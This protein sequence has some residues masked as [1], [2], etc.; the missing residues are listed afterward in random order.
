M[1]IKF[2]TEGGKNIGFGHINRCLSLAQAFQELSFK[3]E[4]NI[5]GDDS[6]KSLIID[7]KLSITDW[8]SNPEFLYNNISID[9]IIVID[10]YKAPELLLTNIA[11]T[12]K[13]LIFFDDFNRVS[14]PTGF[15]VNGALNAEDLFKKRNE[16]SKYLLGPQF[17]T[18]RKEFWNVVPS[19]KRYTIEHILIT[20]G[21]NDLRNL[22]PIVINFLK[23]N[24]PDLIKTVIIGNSFTNIKQINSLKSEKNRIVIN[25]NTKE[26]CELMVR[27]DLAICGAGQTLCELARVKTPALFFGIA[28]NQENNIK[29]WSNI[30]NFNFVGWWNNEDIIGNFRESF[31][32]FE[33]NFKNIAESI[34]SADLIINGQGSKKI[35]EEVMSYVRKN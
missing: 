1:K 6:I 16:K 24:Y 28:D 12:N 21:G 35:V 31:K 27:S 34:Y 30:P 4:F 9:D 19:K 29:S 17:Q 23:E 10:S 20:F 3:C 14:Y 7:F 33:S 18:L 25:P 11:K 26:I 5:I 32:Q 2:F 15:I 13:N 8:I 22:S